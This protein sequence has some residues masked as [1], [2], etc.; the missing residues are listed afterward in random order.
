LLRV[1]EFRRSPELQEAV[2]CGPF[3]VDGGK[4][5]SGLNAIRRAK[6]TAIIEASGKR[7]GLIVT[8]EITLGRQVQS[9]L[10]WNYFPGLK[11]TRA[12]NLDGGSSTGL[13][14][15]VSHRFT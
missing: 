1:G 8:S 4:P 5:V 12:L 2:Q 13:W 3:L 9:S 6:R 14:W 15:R 11:I 7:F 10:H